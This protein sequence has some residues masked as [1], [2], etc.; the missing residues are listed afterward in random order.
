MKVKEL[1]DKLQKRIQENPDE[2]D[3]KIAI[4]IIGESKTGVAPHVEVD[5]V[6][7][8]FDW[9]SGYVFLISDSY[10]LKKS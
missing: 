4:A 1:I 9:N 8:G 7:F 2:A 3:S 10:N 6:L 5:A